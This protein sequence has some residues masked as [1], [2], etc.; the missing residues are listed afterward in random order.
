MD[1]TTETNRRLY[2]LAQAELKEFLNCSFTFFWWGTIFF[3]NIVMPEELSAECFFDIVLTGRFTTD[4]RRAE[5]QRRF[6]VK[7]TEGTAAFLV[8]IPPEVGS[9]L[10]L[11]LMGDEK[12]GEFYL[13]A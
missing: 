1:I 10:L 6:L 8:D 3:N 2:D 11:V 7:A 13:T 4:K 5:R 12:K 9:E